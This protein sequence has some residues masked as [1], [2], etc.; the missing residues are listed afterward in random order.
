MVRSN[1][2]LGAITANLTETNQACQPA[3][4]LVSVAGRL[5]DTYEEEMARISR[6]LTED[7]CQHSTLLAIQ[8]RQISY[9]VPQ[10]TEGKRTSILEFTD[11]ADSI[12]ASVYRLAHELHPFKVE[13]IGL[14]AAFRGLCREY[15]DKWKGHTQR[16]ANVA[17]EIDNRLALCFFRICE[18]TLRSIRNIRRV[19]NLGI[20]LTS[21]DSEIFLHAS[22]NGEGAEIRE[23]NERGLASLT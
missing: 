15:S 3:K 8:A 7:V 17:A 5:V 12:I 10:F 21:K 22:V 11:H 13:L 2:L 9:A 1:T 20:E 4:V 18:A 6:E 19:K 14:S 23:A 16:T